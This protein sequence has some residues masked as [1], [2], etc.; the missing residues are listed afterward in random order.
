MK[1]IVLTV[2]IVNLFMPANGMNF[3]HLQNEVGS[4][5]LTSTNVECSND[6]CSFNGVCVMATN[7]SGIVRVKCSCDSGW[8][9]EECPS[10]S[11]CCNKVKSRVLV[12]LMALFFGELGV[13]YFLIGYT[14]LGVGIL[15]LTCGG[16]IASMLFMCTGGS[17]KA[18]GLLTC[19]A[20]LSVLAA[21]AWWLA[22]V[23]MSA[24]E[25]EMFD[26][27]NVGGW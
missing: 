8:N 1:L 12:F 9:S 6:Y 5:V 21:A 20:G 19:L 14:G 18:A 23:I 15:L 17:E 22:T 25:T 4:N 7:N 3:T 24:A 26:S 27:K 13:P 2:I 10:T 16:C 11:Q